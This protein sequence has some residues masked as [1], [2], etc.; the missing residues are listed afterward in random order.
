MRASIS[1]T[2]IDL[3]SL[4]AE[5]ESDGNGATAVFLGTVRSQNQGRGVTGIEYS[6]YSE[7][8]ER[9]MAAILREAAAQ[10]A[11]GACVIEHRVGVLSVGDASIA[12]VT[13]APHRAAAIDAMRYI[14]EETKR[15]APIWKLE[16]YSDG[17]REWVAAGEQSVPC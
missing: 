7:M 14:V 10:F 5:V 6:S 1:S 16:H 15:R 4:I 13:S 3:Q 9:E 8:A 11:V 2:P 17:A 12:V